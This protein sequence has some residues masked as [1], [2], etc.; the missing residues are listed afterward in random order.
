MAKLTPQKIKWIIQHKERGDL[1]T[2][3]LALIKK[4]TPRKGQSTLGALSANRW[5]TSI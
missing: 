1:S 3:R 5:F 4:V 2:V